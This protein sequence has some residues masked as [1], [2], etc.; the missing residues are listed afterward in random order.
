MFSK[1]VPKLLSL[2]YKLTVKKI[3]PQNPEIANFIGSQIKNIYKTVMIFF[4]KDPNNKEQ[5]QEIWDEIKHELIP[6]ASELVISQLPL[7]KGLGE[8]E[9]TLITEMISG[10]TDLENS[11]FENL[12]SINKGLAV[13]ELQITNPIKDGLK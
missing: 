9:I 13:S 7:I 6:D 8:D 12:M 3:N 4:D 11:E 1:L 2:L 5:L 10:L